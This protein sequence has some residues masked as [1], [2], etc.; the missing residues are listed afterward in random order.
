MSCLI[1][2]SVLDSI[3]MFI[4]NFVINPSLHKCLVLE[5]IRFAD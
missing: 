3:I 5:H 4:M 1:L 2:S